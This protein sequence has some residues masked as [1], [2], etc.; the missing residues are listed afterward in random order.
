MNSSSTIL[1][2]YCRKVSL[3]LKFEDAGLGV[4]GGFVAIILV[5]ILFYDASA[6]ALTI[7]N[8]KYYFINVSCY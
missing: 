3:L 4:F 6:N 8:Y 2:S 7:N 1:A 5:N